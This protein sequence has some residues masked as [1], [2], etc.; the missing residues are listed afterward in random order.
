MLVSFFSRR[1]VSRLASERG[2][3]GDTI[4]T[5]TRQKR[6]ETVHR[7][8]NTWRNTIEILSVF[9]TLSSCN[10]M[11]LASWLH[12]VYKCTSSSSVAEAPESDGWLFPGE[13]PPDKKKRKKQKKKKRRRRDKEKKERIRSSLR[14][15]S[16][17]LHWSWLSRAPMPIPAHTRNSL[18]FFRLT[19]SV[20][21]KSSAASP[22]R[23]QFR[24]LDPWVAS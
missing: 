16:N 6:N 23:A 21:L 7:P 24:S 12:F 18:N 11:R 20:D 4:G 19:S 17:A 3:R 15:L 22:S 10:H 14:P 8:S 9:S 5:G 1:G 2:D 13:T